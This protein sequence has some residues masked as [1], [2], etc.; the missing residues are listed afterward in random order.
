VTTPDEGKMTPPE[1]IRG[2]F[3]FSSCEFRTL[4]ISE[5]NH[6]EADMSNRVLAGMAVATALTVGVIGSAALAETPPPSPSPTTAPA[7]PKTQEPSYTGSIRV[8]E[9]TGDESEAAETAALAKLAKISEADAT[10]AA[11]ARFPGATVQ[12]AS[13]ED[14]N[15]N[16]VWSV[17]LTDASKAAQEVKV[18]AG[19]GAIL[20][21]EAGGAEG[22]KPGSED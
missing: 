1:T 12:K 11:L 4:V 15:G 13:L 18:D 10:K 21:V 16:V 3:M 8:A 20:A 22:E 14:E 9:G 19:N 2:E 5:P 17:Q 7:G 6:R